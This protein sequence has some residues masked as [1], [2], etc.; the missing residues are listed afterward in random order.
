MGKPKQH[1][2]IE[3]ISLGPWTIYTSPSSLWVYARHYLQAAQRAP[4]GKF[5]PARIYLACH[6]ME[7]SLKA[8]LSLKGFSL[9]DLAG[10]AFSHNLE[11]ILAEAESRDLLSIVDLTDAE[12]TE[13]SLASN[14]Y[15]EKVF[16]YPATDE[17][18]FAY[19]K[20]PKA[21]DLLVDA[22]EK[23]VLGLRDPCRIIQPG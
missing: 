8:F 14:Y 2:K 1:Q 7:L 3:S 10:G 22:A 16:E 4:K 19:P 11:K 18:I 17:A 20:Y 12:L 13:I 21:P 5:A 15:A 6:S 23:L 9:E